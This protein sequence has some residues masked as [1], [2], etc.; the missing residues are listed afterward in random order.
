MLLLEDEEARSGD[1]KAIVIKV[2]S[3]LL[4]VEKFIF[5]CSR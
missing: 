1:K 2:E 3:P 5:F 4:K